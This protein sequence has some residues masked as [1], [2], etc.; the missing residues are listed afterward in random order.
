M[1]Q[2]AMLRFPEL[3]NVFAAVLVTTTL[4]SAP[5]IMWSSSNDDQWNNVKQV[6]R[7]TNY[8]F[9]T[10]D[11]DCLGGK[12][13]HIDESVITIMRR[14]APEITIQRTDLLRITSG[15]WAPGV[16]FS[17]R[18]SWSDVV[19]IAGKHFYATIAV[20]TK[21]GQEHKGKLLSV[22]DKAMALES[23]GKNVTI[24]KNEVSTVSYIRPKPL[25]E[26]AAYADDELAWMKIFDPQLWPRL[27]HLQSLL[28]IR[29][30]DASLPEGNSAIV[31]NSDPWLQR[32]PGPDVTRPP[33]PPQ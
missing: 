24:A 19:N 12:V 14:N 17:G 8:I 7:R 1:A 25:S 20:L 16:I 23:S 2:L 10:R 15:E 9:V 28:S 18:S 22:S 6:T 26:S 4:C 27:L 31:C 11:H 5:P 30:Y 29:L 13:K 32:Q 3:T 33:F 21:S